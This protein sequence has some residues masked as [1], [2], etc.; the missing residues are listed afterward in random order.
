MKLAIR[1]IWLSSIVYGLSLSLG[2]GAAGAKR[3]STAASAEAGEDAPEGE[4][5][6]TLL[7][8]TKTCTTTG[9][10]TVTATISG[11][12][13]ALKL[14]DALPPLAPAPAPAAPAAAP[15]TTAPAATKNCTPATTTETTPTVTPSTGTEPPG[16]LPPATGNGSGTA[17]TQPPTGTQTPPLGTLLTGKTLEQCN[18]EGKAWVLPNSTGPA[19]CGDALVNWCCSMPEISNQ[20]PAFAA[21]LSQTI[22]SNNTSG[23]KLYN[24]SYANSKFTMHF[25]KS[26]ATGLRIATS[27]ISGV[28]PTPKAA[29]TSCP[30]PK[31]ASLG[32]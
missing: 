30:L 14:E 29:P 28:T 20:F 16:V 12:P 24:C 26:D 7:Q 9:T 15:A 5:A 2:C 8:K 11:T 25:A 3:A 4:D 22:T 10:G 13:S 19:T 18:A 31:A 23:L 32:L 6:K 21:Q 1:G 17:A 27:Y